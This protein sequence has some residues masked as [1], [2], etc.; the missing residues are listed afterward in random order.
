M[1]HAP[2]LTRAAVGR[3]SLH[4]RGLLPSHRG[5]GVHAGAP[6][7][8]SC[9][10][11]VTS[12]RWAGVPGRTKA[13][14]GPRVLW[15]HVRD[16]AARP[17]PQRPPPCT[18]SRTK[19]LRFLSAPRPQASVGISCSPSWR[20]RSASVGISTPPPSCAATMPSAH[21]AT[22]TRGSSAAACVCKA[23]SR[24]GLWPPP[25]AG[26]DTSGR[27]RR[28]LLCCCHTDP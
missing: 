10:C 4:L 26:F 6:T 17:P 9:P 8:A 24:Q 5:R 18:Q 19:A 23:S 11:G 16:L 2:T 20:A 12:G 22:S 1:P 13:R 28:R 7:P 14:H 15:P 27:M 25:C 21:R 3:V